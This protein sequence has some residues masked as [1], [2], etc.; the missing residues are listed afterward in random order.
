M[1]TAR[2]PLAGYRTTLTLLV[3]AYT[4]SPEGDEWILNGVI[5]DQHDISL[6]LVVQAHL[7]LER[8]F[9]SS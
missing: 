7:I 4:L 8:R 9:V 2:Q 5:K 3:L 6:D 1:G